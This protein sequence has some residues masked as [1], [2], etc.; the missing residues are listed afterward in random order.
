MISFILWY[1]SQTSKSFTHYKELYINVAV[2]VI[3]KYQKSSKYVQQ[4][5]M[6]KQTLTYPNN[7]T[8]IKRMNY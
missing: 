5:V 2:F 4:Q 6:D 7:G 3:A 8:V 1:L